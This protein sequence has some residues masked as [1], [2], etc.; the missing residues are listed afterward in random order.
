MKLQNAV[1][2]LRK[3]CCHPY[4]FDWPIDSSTDMPKISNELIAAS[5]KMMLMEKLLEALFERGHKVLVFSQFT[6]MLDIIYD[7]ASIFKKW[8]VCRLDGS[9]SQ[10]DRR[11]QVLK[12]FFYFLN[13]VT[14]QLR[15][16]FFCFLDS[17]F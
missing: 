12:K 5:G 17:R 1:M 14:I 2:Q 4:L 7:W 8:K 13:L 3:V 6:T 15:T 10:E 16:F 9:V 11:Q